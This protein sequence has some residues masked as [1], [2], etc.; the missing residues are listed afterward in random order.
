M[1]K[2]LLATVVAIS[3][4]VTMPTAKAQFAVIDLHNGRCAA[5]PGRKATR[6][7]LRRLRRSVRG[8]PIA[9]RDALRFAVR[10]L[11]AAGLGEHCRLFPGQ[12]PRYRPGGL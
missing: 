2:T 11:R 9:R 5:H 4:I 8:L 7:M 3:L 1:R 12:Y 6:R 10:F